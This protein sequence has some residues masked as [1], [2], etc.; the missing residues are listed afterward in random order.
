MK[1]GIRVRAP[2]H[3]NALRV[4][5]FPLGLPKGTLAHPHPPQ[6]SLSG[7]VDAASTKSA[8]KASP[9]FH[10]PLTTPD[11]HP[12]PPGD[13]NKGRV[14]GECSRHTCSHRS[15]SNHAA[16]AWRDVDAAFCPTTAM[17]RVF[18]TVQPCRDNSRRQ[19]PYFAALK[20]SPDVDAAF[21]ALPIK[22]RT[23][24]R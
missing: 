3:Q 17:Q 19:L 13:V 14:A 6:L 2:A 5:V 10:E 8:E 11:P 4:S 21:T 18:P 23:A 15:L 7:R 9:I 24:E 12:A 22:G 20:S 1:N 16:A